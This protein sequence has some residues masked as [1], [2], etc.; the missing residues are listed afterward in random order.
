MSREQL[1]FKQA[2][3]VCKILGIKNDRLKYFKKMGIFVSE[4]KKKGYTVNDIERLK[5]LVVLTKAGLTCDD[6]K[7]VNLGN[8]SL[9]EAIEQRRNIMEGKLAQIQGALSLSAELLESN[10]QYD[11]LPSDFYLGEI[12][13]RENNGEEFMDCDNWKFELEMV[14][15]IQCPNCGFF[16]TI[17]LEDYVYS[18]SSDEKENGMGPDFVRYFDSE[19]NY[20]CPKCGKVIQI[21]GWKREYP[22]GAFDSQDIDLSLIEEIDE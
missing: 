20:K 13:R 16:S 3:E 7:N 8:L 14:E 11:S 22:V 6:I 18:E 17:D 12:Q 9:T 19:D 10:V 15:H 2:K 4:T 21:S 5:K 1:S